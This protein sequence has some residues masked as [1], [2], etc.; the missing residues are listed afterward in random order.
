MPCCIG[1][2]IG[3][4]CCLVSVS[5]AQ[6]KAHTLNDMSPPCHEFL[7]LATL[8]IIINTIYASCRKLLAAT[9]Q[10]CASSYF[11]SPRRRDG[12]EIHHPEPPTNYVRVGCYFISAPYSFQSEFDRA[13]PELVI[14]PREDIYFTLLPSGSRTLRP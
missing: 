14:F 9:Y 13:K 1:A 5:I 7:T 12:A 4:T 3:G 2:G 6:L 10:T 8:R 11:N